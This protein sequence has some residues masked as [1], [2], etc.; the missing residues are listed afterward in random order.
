MPESSARNVFVLFVAVALVGSAAMV[1]V[2]FGQE[3]GTDDA[4][5]ETEVTTQSTSYLRVAHAAPGAGAVDVYVDNQSVASNVP[6]GTVSDYLSLEA[7]NHTVTV[8]AVGVRDAVVFEE[9]VVLDARSV[10]TVAATLNDSDIENASVVPQAYTD[11]ARTPA[12]GEAALRL[13]HLSP[14]APAVDIV[15][16]GD[17]ATDNETEAGNETE[18]EAGN[19]TETDAVNETETE[20]GNE[21]ETDA[22]DETATDDGETSETVLAEDLA[23]TD[24]TDYLT[25]PAGDYT[26]E[27]RTAD[28]NATVVATIDVSLES[29]TAYSAWAIGNVPDGDAPPP[30]F[31]VL[32]TEDASQTFEFPA[33]APGTP[34]NETETPTEN[35][36]ETVTEE[37]ETITEENETETGTTETE[38][39]TEENETATGETETV[40][41]ETETEETETVTEETDTEATE[42]VTDETETVTEAT[43]TE[44]E[45]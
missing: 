18:T 22:V 32:A 9:T 14:N 12:D 24:A 13:V 8:T 16:V 34:A 29:G 15:A 10:T 17:G 19:E 20:A 26:V 1:G 36:T 42:T 41:D 6:F 39:I 23:Y 25:V 5:N 21:T 44:T 35:V 38:T 3:T 43:E 7:G 45:S 37:T 30:T 11:D 31:R 33:G 28:E 27:I 40:T 2:G 4:G